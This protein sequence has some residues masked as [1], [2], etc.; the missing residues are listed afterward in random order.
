MTVDFDN[1]W[2]VGLVVGGLEAAQEQLGAAFGHEWSTILERE[3]PVHLVDRGQSS[4]VRWSASRG[5][6]PQWEVIE[7]ESGLWSVGENPGR[8]L[9]HLAYWSDDLTGD[10]AALQAS[11]YEL[12]AWGD[13]EHGVTRFL[14]LLGPNGLRIE[15]GAVETRPA[16]EEWTSGG[17]YGIRF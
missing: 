5:G 17:D 8:G 10:G 7:A 1:L 3:V 2:H 11:G 14:Y 12:E 9:H 13:D 6:R 15:I 16:W 4:R